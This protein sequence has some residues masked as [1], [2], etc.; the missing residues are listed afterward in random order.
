MQA[1]ILSV[2]RTSSGVARRPDDS[3]QPHVLGGTAMT[4][5]MFAAELDFQSFRR[6]GPGGDVGDRRRGRGGIEGTV[7]GNEG[8]GVALSIHS[9]VAI[10]LYS[11]P[12]ANLDVLGRTAKDRSILPADDAFR[13]RRRG[14]GG[15]EGTVGGKEGRVASSAHSL[16]AILL[17]NGVLANLHINLAEQRG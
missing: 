16:V 13:H 8:G 17:G 5:S 15:D 11:S 2:T 6:R 10:L 3:H 12:V 7:G 14:L 1:G 4:R 9:L